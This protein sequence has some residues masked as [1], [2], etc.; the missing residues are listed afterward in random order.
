[1]IKRESFD[2]TLKGSWIW[3]SFQTLDSLIVKLLLSMKTIH[4]SLDFLLQ[5][6]YHEPLIQNLREY[7]P[8]LEEESLIIPVVSSKNYF[9]RASEKS[10]S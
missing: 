9:A 4:S 1:M 3:N 7:S 8:N 2:S 10:E 6:L 5:S